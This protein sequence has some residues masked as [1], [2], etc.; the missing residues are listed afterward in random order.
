MLVIANSH[1]ALNIE[2]LSMGVER[3]SPN[4][5]LYTTT[6]NVERMSQPSHDQHERVRGGS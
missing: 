4:I 1:F 3:G 2:N 6:E 5:L